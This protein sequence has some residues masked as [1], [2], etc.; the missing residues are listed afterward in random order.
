MQKKNYK[1]D[2]KKELKQSWYDLNDRKSYLIIALLCFMCYGNTIFNGYSLD[3]DLNVTNNNYVQKGLAGIPDILTH[4]YASWAGKSGDYRP[5]AAITYAIENQAFHGNPHVSHLFSIIFFIICV[6]L[7]FRVLTEVFSLDRLHP[8]LPLVICAFFVVH[9][10][11]TEVVSSI[12]NREEI[13]SL[14]FGMLSLLYA[15]RF[16]ESQNNLK[17]AFTA[18]SL[19]VL[20]VIS[21]VTVIPMIGVFLLLAFYNRTAK[22]KRNYWIFSA[23]MMVLAVCYF[24]LMWYFVKRQFYDLENPLVLTHDISIKL[25]TA[26]A[27]LMFYF[28]MLFFPY[29]LSFY[30]GYNTI[31]LISFGEPVSFFSVIIHVV[32]LWYGIRL[33]LKKNA[34]GF[35]LVSYFMCI[36]PYS[37]LAVIYTGIVY[38]RAFFFPGLWLLAAVVVIVFSWAGFGKTNR[39]GGSFTQ[40][41]VLFTGLLFFASFSW[42]TVQRNFQWKDTLTLLSADITHL[43][44]STLANFFYAS[45]LQETGEADGS[46]GTGDIALAK[47]YYRQSLSVSPGYSQPYYKLGMIYEYDEH[48]NDSAFVCFKTAHKLDTSLTPV[49]FQLA[50]LYSIHGDYKSANKLFEKVYKEIPADTFNLF[51]YAQSLFFSGDSAKAFGINDTLLAYAPGDFH[52]YLNRGMFNKLKGNTPSA[53]NDLERVLQLGYRNQIVINALGECYAKMGQADKI[54]ALRKYGEMQNNNP[55]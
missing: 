43:E 27:T 36:F 28:K 20:A 30:Y 25:G 5:M 33:L 17:L 40:K 39:G 2:N 49:N 23:I 34:A 22:T 14:L 46:S 13:L 42:I 3:D 29:P 19:F 16:L 9:P 26:M 8:V 6:C 32:L 54:V 45:L 44:N 31:P 55:K 41:V 11:H 10:M 48:N 4:P 53:E 37:N 50:K 7:I 15:H 38:E 24:G 1:P 21:K 12:K 18:L 51:F 35:F 52:G 47:K